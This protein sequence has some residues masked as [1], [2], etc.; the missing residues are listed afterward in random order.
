MKSWLDIY[1]LL[2]SKDFINKLKTYE[3]NFKKNKYTDYYITP[4][5][6]F[7]IYISKYPSGSNYVRIYGDYEG[8]VEFKKPYINGNISI[9]YLPNI[10]YEDEESDFC[11]IDINTKK[12][13][14][15]NSAFDSDPVIIFTN[16]QQFF[17]Y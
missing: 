6:K 7:R 4:D 17:D 13:R 1:N 3:P 15:Y 12:E 11:E 2:I 16:F 10:Y 14:K 8:W 5:G 9:H